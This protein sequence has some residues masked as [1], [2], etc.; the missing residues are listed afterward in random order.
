MPN[1]CAAGLPIGVA[2]CEWCGA[3]EDEA[4]RKI[5][6]MS[7]A[8]IKENVAAAKAGNPPPHY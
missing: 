8:E 2:K 7:P 1:L 4:C 6:W 5:E 3:T